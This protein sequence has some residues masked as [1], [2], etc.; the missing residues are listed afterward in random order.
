MLSQMKRLALE[1]DG[2]YATDEELQFLVDYTRCCSTRIETYQRL[3]ELEG[4]I[5]EE[6]LTQ[7]QATHPGLLSSHGDNIIDKW[8]RD[9]LRVLR[10][11]AIAM[12]LDDPDTLQERF[13]LW[14]QTIMRAFNAQKSC[15]A[16]Y[17]AM[18]AVVKRHLTPL[19]TSLFCP[20]LE[21]NRQVLGKSST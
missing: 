16:T 19:Q 2:R 13:L 9:T 12:L 6:A 18:Q 5:V 11:S 20:I 21:L 4:A 17:D 14:F 15:D 1:T 8:K 10:F 3:Q 7:L